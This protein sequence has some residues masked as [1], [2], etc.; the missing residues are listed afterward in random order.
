MKIGRL[1]LKNIATG[2][3]RSSSVGNTGETFAGNGVDAYDDDG[4]LT[5]IAN[6]QGVTTYTWNAENRLLAV[7]PQNAVE[8]GKKA[9][10]HGQAV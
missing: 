9:G 5:S 7:Q 10:F 2:T 3:G 4:N 6:A 8:G 1:E